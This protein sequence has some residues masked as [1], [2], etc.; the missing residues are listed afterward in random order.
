[1][2]ATPRADALHARRRSTTALL[3]NLCG[4]LDANLRQIEAAFDVTITHRGGD[5]AIAG[6][7]R[8]SR[9]GGAKRSSASTRARRSRSRSTTSSSAWSRSRRTVTV[10]PRPTS[11]R[12]RRRCCAR[13]ASTCT[14]RTPNQVAVPARTSR[15][16]TSRSASGPPGTG[17]T[18]LAVAV[19]G[20]RARARRGQA[21]RPRAPRGRGRRAAGLPARRPRAEGRSRTCGR[22]TTRSTT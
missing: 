17:K 16:T 8:A 22:S 11:R 2:I 18:Y 1:M 5:F 6:A 10:T 9:E 4:P 12:R 20:R 7:R 19:R 13:A 3:A 15:R 14:A 21:H